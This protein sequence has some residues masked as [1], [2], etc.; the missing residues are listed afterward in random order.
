MYW[1]I[2]AS[3]QVLLRPGSI[4]P[5]LQMRKLWKGGE[6]FTKSVVWYGQRDLKLFPSGSVQWG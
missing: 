5:I 6:R 1:S 4:P 2:L 3:H